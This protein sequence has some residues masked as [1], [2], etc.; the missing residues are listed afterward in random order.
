MTAEAKTKGSEFKEELKTSID[1]ITAVAE[2]IQNGKKVDEK[3]LRSMIANA[4]INVNHP[5]L[6]SENIYMLTEPEN[7]T[8]YRRGTSLDYNLKSLKVGTI[9]LKGDAKN[10]GEKLEIEGKK[11]KEELKAW[12]DRAELHASKTLEHFRKYQSEYV[13]G[14]Y[15]MY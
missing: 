5:Y 2:A 15:P 13:M 11:L 9:K 14:M 12:N 3:E 10:E 6:A 1:K 7:V 4:E 8:N